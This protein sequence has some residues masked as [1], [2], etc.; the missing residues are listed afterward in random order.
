MQKR[1]IFSRNPLIVA[2][3]QNFEER[4]THSYMC[5]TQSF[6]EDTKKTHNLLKRI[7]IVANLQNIVERERLTHAQICVIGC[8]NNEV[9]TLCRVPKN[10]GFFLQKSPT[11]IGALLQKS[12]DLYV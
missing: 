3:L 2:N 7:L 6:K 4:N 8:H 1:S 5:D 12:R 11:K 9:A 10:I